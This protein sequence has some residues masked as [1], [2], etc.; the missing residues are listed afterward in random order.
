MNSAQN[1]F[2][3]LIR[4]IGLI[5]LILLVSPLVH[6]QDAATNAPTTDPT[7]AVSPAPPLPP[8]VAS[9][10]IVT[11]NAGT[12][13]PPTDIDDIRPPFFFLHFG[14]IILAVLALIVLI[15]LI[16]LIWKWLS[17]S[18]YLSPKSAYELTLEKLEKAR[19]LLREEDPVPYAVF[20]SETIRSYLGHR[21]QTPS[22][23]RTTEEFLRMMEADAGTPLAAH[24]DLL[25]QF[26]QACDLVKFAKY[27]PT[28][29]ELEEV[30]HRA[31]SF[32]HATNPALDKIVTTGGKP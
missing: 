12:P 25:R 28:Q 24:S 29:A 31:L 21:F 17:K 10:Q 20:V 1:V 11:P 19:A 32:V 5:S 13:V 2:I 30:Q 23:R 3:R 8:T 27:Q 16:I 14:P 18:A 4:P 22:T 9:P 7:P 15:G 6:A 26:L